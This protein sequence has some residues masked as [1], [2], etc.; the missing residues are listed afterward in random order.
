MYI[1]AL[2]DNMVQFKSNMQV[3]SSGRKKDVYR[4][5]DKNCRY[6]LQM[7]EIFYIGPYKAIVQVQAPHELRQIKN[8]VNLENFETPGGDDEAYGEEKVEI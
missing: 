4:Y 5:I 7:E 6:V 3:E 2:C 1:E 8:V